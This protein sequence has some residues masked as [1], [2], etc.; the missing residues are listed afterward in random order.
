[1]TIDY[2]ALRDN[3]GYA[4]NIDRHTALGRRAIAGYISAVAIAAGFPDMG[5]DPVDLEWFDEA[6]AVDGM[7]PLEWIECML[8]D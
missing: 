8:M 4:D 5:I 2:D 6:W 1:M 7:E 3:P